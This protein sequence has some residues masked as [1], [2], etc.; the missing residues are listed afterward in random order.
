MEE[1]A[2]DKDLISGI[3]GGDSEYLDYFVSLYLPKVYNYVFIRV[4]DRRRAEVLTETILTE[5]VHAFDRYDGS[6]SLDGWIF[7][8]T[9]EVLQFQKAPLR[10]ALLKTS[11]SSLL[12]FNYC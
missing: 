5:A 10:A 7:Q 8:I 6:R 9:E 4:P 2:K 12:R 1:K 3:I 11:K